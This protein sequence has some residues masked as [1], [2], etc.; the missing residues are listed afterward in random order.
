MSPR[1][2]RP[3]ASSSEG[4]RMDSEATGAQEYAETG[5]SEHRGGVRFSPNA[6]RTMRT[7]E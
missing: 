4:K 1:P 3:G 5:P 2:A 7:A 6:L